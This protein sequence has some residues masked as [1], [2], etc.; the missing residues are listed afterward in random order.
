MPIIHPRP[1]FFRDLFEGLGRVGRKCSCVIVC[2]DRRLDRTI[3]VI[4][5][6]WWHRWRSVHVFRIRLPLAGRYFDGHQAGQALLLSRTI[7]R[8]E[9]ASYSHYRWWYRI[10]PRCWPGTAQ[11]CFHR[12]HVIVM[13]SCGRR[14]RVRKICCRNGG[15]A[16]FISGVLLSS[17]CQS[18][19]PLALNLAAVS[20]AVLLAVAIA[21]TITRAVIARLVI[22]NLAVPWRR[23]TLSAP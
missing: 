23:S 21:R 7:Q 14:M 16:A 4:L 18:L 2:I 5:G 15:S 20:L 8:R 10:L 11:V 22:R 6:K 19:N 13:T 17:N 3:C 9:F 1:Q 12:L